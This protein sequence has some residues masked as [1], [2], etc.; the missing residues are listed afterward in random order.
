MTQK[1]IDVTGIGNAIVDVIAL[2]DDSF[3]EDMHIPK[4]SMTLIDA[5]RANSL[6]ATL[7]SPLKRSGGSAANT[8]FGL[9]KMGATTAFVGKVNDDELGSIFS[10]DIR[11]AGISFDVDVVEGGAPTATCIVLVTPDAQRSMNTHLGASSNLRP[12]DIPDEKIKQSKI[13]YLEG[14]LWDRPNAKAAFLK[15]SELASKADT[16]VALTLSDPFCVDRHR[17]DFLKLI[18]NHVGILFANEE[19]LLSLYQVTDLQN[20]I[21]CGYLDCDLLAITCGAKG[22]IIASNRE[23]MKLEAEQ[24]QSVVDTTGAGDLFAAGFLF[25]FT[26]GMDSRLCGQLGSI[27]AAEINSHYGARPEGDLKQLISQAISRA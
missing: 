15:A 9:A 1:P 12:T 16:K 27:A 26:I 18:K 5:S 10:R 13:L 24:T 19:E 3:L 11:A 7:N 23:Q 14:Y 8:I 21:V 25:G 20:A 22:S 17:E 2:V 4:G 6:Y